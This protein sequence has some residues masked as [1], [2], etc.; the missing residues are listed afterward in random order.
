[1]YKQRNA[2]CP[3]RGRKFHLRAISQVTSHSAHG[4]A[5]NTIPRC[6]LHAANRTSR[7]LEVHNA[8]LINTEGPGYASLVPRVHSAAAQADSRLDAALCY[9]PRA[10]PLGPGI[11]RFPGPVMHS[12]LL[13][14]PSS[15]IVAIRTAMCWNFH[16]LLLPPFEDARRDSQAMVKIGVPQMPP[17]RRC[18]CV[19]PGPQK[20]LRPGGGVRRCDGVRKA[21]GAHAGQRVDRGRV[22]MLEGSDPLHSLLRFEVI[23]IVWRHWFLMD[24]YE[25]SQNRIL[26]VAFK[27]ESA[28]NGTERLTYRDQS[29][30]MVPQQFQSPLDT[31]ER[32]VEDDELSVGIFFTFSDRKFLPTSQV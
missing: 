2:G 21:L 13:C 32:C 11:S 9:C 18:R 28:S 7:T 16:I 1:M 27:L 3:P 20:S 26:W 22:D 12:L 6:R 29:R 8:A 25:Y 5:P 30:R 19:V 31:D 15:E 24:Q 23:G 4:K 17:V 14:S 10:M